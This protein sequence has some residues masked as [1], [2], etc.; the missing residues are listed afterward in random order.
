MIQSD[1]VRPAKGYGMR[2]YLLHP[3][4]FFI[5]LDG[6]AIPNQYKKPMQHLS[7]ATAQR[8]LNQLARHSHRK[9]SP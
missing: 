4:K 3:G 6:E 1:R 8:R 2:E 5:T 7:L 9:K